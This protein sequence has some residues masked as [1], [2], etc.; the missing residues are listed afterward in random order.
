MWN[1]VKWL[2]HLCCSV[3]TEGNDHWSTVMVC[4]QNPRYLCYANIQRN[5][6][7]C[8]TETWFCYSQGVWKCSG[9]A[10]SQVAISSKCS[11]FFSTFANFLFIGNF[12]K[13][14]TTWFTRFWYL[15]RS[16]WIDII[17]ENKVKRLRLLL[18]QI[19][20]TI[21]LVF[22]EKIYQWYVVN[23]LLP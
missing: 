12:L 2:I 15:F 18:A 5:R 23:K 7:D 21:K 14:S 6:G 11:M 10:F 19:T 8:S 4:P 20:L 17:N 3:W 22:F 13:I 9:L 16:S 1:A